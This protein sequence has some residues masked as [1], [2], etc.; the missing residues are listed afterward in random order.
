MAYIAGFCR[1]LCPLAEHRVIVTQWFGT[2]TDID[3]QKRAEQGQHVLAEVGRLLTSSLDYH[4]TLASICGL[5][6]P[7]L[8]DWCSLELLNDDGQVEYLEVAHA[9][10][11]KVELAHEY[12]RMYPPRQDDRSG[13]MKVFR[14][15]EPEFWP[16]VTD[17]QLVVECSRSRG[18]E[19]TACAGDRSR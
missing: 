8:A 1:V 9:D 11:A 4:A 13:L 14:T 7:A 16:E 15:G 6:V 12:R 2:F 3:G 17:E 19:A 5:A 10:R 18:T